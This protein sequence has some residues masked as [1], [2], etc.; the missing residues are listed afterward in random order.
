[1]DYEMHNTKYKDY[2]KVGGVKCNR[3]D[4]LPDKSKRRVF[5]DYIIKQD[6]VS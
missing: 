6:L 2:V 1:M 3:K 5:T 4:W